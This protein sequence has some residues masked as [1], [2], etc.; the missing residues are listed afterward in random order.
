M[1]L[2]HVSIGSNDIAAARCFYLKVLK[3][4]GMVIVEEAAGQFVDFGIDSIEFS[5]ETPLDGKP[6]TT[7]NG[8]HICFLAPS[9]AAVIAFY[10]AAISAGGRCVGPP[11]LRPHYHPNYFGAFIF[12]IDG[13]KIEAVYHK[14]ED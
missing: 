4:L 9:R 10:Q 6:A 2:D 5:V 11:G 1:P 14:A 3:P 7:G 12:D 8:V 13:N